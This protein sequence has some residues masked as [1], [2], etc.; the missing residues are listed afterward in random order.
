MRNTYFYG[1]GFCVGMR[2]GLTFHSF[3]LYK[4]TNWTRSVGSPI[5]Q[6]HGSSFNYQIVDLLD[7]FLPLHL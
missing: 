5:I 1:F 2:Q 4:A 7:L 6:D 3:Y